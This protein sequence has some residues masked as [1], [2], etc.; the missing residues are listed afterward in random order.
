M[1]TDIE[2]LGLTAGDGPGHF[3]FTVENHLARLDGLLYGGTAIA[4]S[5]ATAEALTNRS[6]LWMT[7]QFIATAP[8]NERISVHTEVLAPGRRTNQVRVTGTDAAG[9]IMFASLGATGH[10]KESGLAGTFDQAPT[11]SPPER[12]EPWPNPFVAVVRNAGIEADFSNFP[13]DLGFNAALDLREPTVEAHPD[14]GPGRMCVW[15]RRRD[16][17]A[18][19]PAIASYVADMVP[20]SVA[21]AC[22]VMAGGISL[23]NTIRIGAFETTE[24]VLIDLRP[25]LAVGDYGHGTAH[26]WSES[27]ALLATASQTS[28][29]MRF[30]PTDF[31]AAKPSPGE[32]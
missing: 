7:T 12:S 25:H 13:T 27:G 14:P 5:I 15:A 31:A 20:L 26:V 2:F 11:V 8:A 3:H 28:S 9:D 10:H 22:G 18:I 32:G 1:D 19:T 23:D 17:V 4:V 30:S 24:W 21:H 6:P 29:M 16:Q